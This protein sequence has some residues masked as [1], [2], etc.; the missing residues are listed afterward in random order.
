[1]KYAFIRSQQ[2]CY[3][4]RRLCAVLEV[5][6][7][8]YYGWLRQPLSARARAD[9]SLGQ[10]LQRLHYSYRQAYGTRRLQ[11]ALRDEGL[12]VGRGRIRRLKRQLNLWTRRRRRAWRHH[13]AHPRPVIKA[14]RLNRQ[15]AA[16]APNRVWTADVTSLWT[17]Q[18]WLHLAVVLD[19]YA[20]RVVGWAFD[21]RAGQELTLA[22]L[23]QALRR[24]RPAPGLLHH[25]DR[26]PHYTARRYQNRL[27][28]RR[29]VSSMSRP[30]DCYD[31][32][33]TESFFSTLKSEFAHHRRFLTRQQARE[34][35]SDYIERFYNRIRMHSTLGY[36]SP[37]EYETMAVLS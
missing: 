22:A 11:R 14:N 37:C 32:A 2:R 13:Q 29:I 8:A 27:R 35:I 30:G 17:R 3:P 23:N 7:S 1:M 36:R 5:S 34:E 6:P 15:F 18:G 33:P 19:L 20:R 26:G 25:S 4:V 28:Q 10:V 31:N 9:Q 24:R 16:A 21:R 12:R